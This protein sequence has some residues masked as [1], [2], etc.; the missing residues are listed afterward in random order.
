MTNDEFRHSFKVSVHNS[1][2]LAVYSC[3]IQRCGSCHSWGPAIRDHY[4]IHYIISGHGVFTSGGNSYPLSAG[5]GFLVEPSRIASYSADKADPWEY[6][7]VGF[8]GSDAKRLMLQTGLLNRNPVFHCDDV[9]RLQ[10]LLENINSVSGSSPSEEA[11]ME[12]ALLLFL[13]EMMD[14]FGSRSAQHEN[15]YDYVQKAIKFID[16]N[17]SSDIDVNDVAASAEISRSHLYRLFMQHISMPPNEY[18][19]RYRIS[20]GAELLESNRFSVGEVAFSTGFSDQLYFSR[21]FK[22][23]MGVPP[24]RYAAHNRKEDKK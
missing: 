1:L 11:R 19:M 4:L 3:G 13:A 18:L 5:D 14:Q 12:S 23:Y 20:K 22:K 21:V 17:Y 24:S 9:G 7:W 15:G 16:Y 6:C 8:N 10:Q 2:G